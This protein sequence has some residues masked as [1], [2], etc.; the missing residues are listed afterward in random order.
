MDHSTG[1]GAEGEL[2]RFT[3]DS[4]T[5]AAG[6]I[7]P[8]AFTSSASAIRRKANRQPSFIRGYGFQ[9][10]AGVDSTFD[11][12]GIWRRLQASGEARE[13]TA[14][15]LGAFGESLA[16]DDNFVAI[17]P[18]LKDAWGIPALHISMT[19]GENEAHHARRRGRDRGGDAGGCRRQEHPSPAR[20]VANPAW[21]FTNWVRRAWGTIRRSR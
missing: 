18:N 4:P 13:R 10:G 11:A 16:R 12:A 6:R 1:G 15:A 14:S 9:G 21:P 3:N 20:T 2:P 19:H 5:R 17:D 8:M 7:A